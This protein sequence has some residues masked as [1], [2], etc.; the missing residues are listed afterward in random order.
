MTS[1]TINSN[2]VD[3][4]KYYANEAE[5]T[6]A[7]AASG[8]DRSQIF[9]TTKVPAGCMSYEKAKQAIGESLGAAEKL[10]YIDLY[11]LYLLDG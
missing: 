3:S 9:Y 8:I 6:S 4:A 2:Q 1:S 11:V 5:C 7:I 10:G